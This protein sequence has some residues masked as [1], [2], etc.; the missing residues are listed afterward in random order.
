MKYVHD[1]TQITNQKECVVVLGNFDGIHIG[2]QKLLE[3]AREEAKYKKIEVVVF[4]FYPPPTWVL[5]DKKKKLITSREEKV[6]L[7]KEYGVNTFIEYPF[8][9]EFSKITPSDFVRDILVKKLKAKSIVIGRNY[10]FGKRREGDSEY[11]KNIGKDNAMDVSVVDT[12]KIENRV[13]SSSVIRDLI[14][15]GN[16]ELV[17]KMLGRNYSVEGTVMHGKK[18]GRTIGFPTAN[19]STD[20]NRVYPPNG[21]YATSI[22]LE[23]KTYLGITN[24]GINPTVLGKNKVIETN[25]FDFNGDIYDKNIEIS[26]Y[27]YIRSEKKFQSLDELK[28]QISE[29]SYQVRRFFCK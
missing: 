8:D 18:L 4:S 9:I 24:I 11:L 27:K 22:N 7:M 2:H 28:N 16:I 15:E 12:V 10:H 3:K 13:V 25:I 17:S 21:V 14:A 19:L 23:D 5:S 29:D 26:F 6:K 1:S 20:N